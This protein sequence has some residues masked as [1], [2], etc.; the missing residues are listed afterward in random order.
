MCGS[1]VDIFSFVAPISAIGG[2]IFG[3]AFARS[4]AFKAIDRQEF[5][6]DY[7][8]LK[9]SFI[10]T[11]RILRKDKQAREDIISLA[12]LFESQMSAMLAFSFHL[13][14]KNER[15]FEEKWN[16]YEKWN[17]EYDKLEAELPDQGKFNTVRRVDEIQ[18]MVKEI[19]EAAKKC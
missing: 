3:A 14:S 18:S 6:R 10:P 16:K 1:S 4:T 19:L 9:N 5:N 15:N 13:T 8:T 2:V 7:L 12:N 17:Q 11:L